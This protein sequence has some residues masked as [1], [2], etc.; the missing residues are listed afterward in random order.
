MLRPRRTLVV[1]RAGGIVLR[2]RYTRELGSPADRLLY[3][4]AIRGAL[5][6]AAIA[7]RL[8]SGDVRTYASYLLALV[9]GLLALARLGALG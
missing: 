8:Q 5:A 4:P 7:R 1:E 2:L 3:R 6:G 9:I